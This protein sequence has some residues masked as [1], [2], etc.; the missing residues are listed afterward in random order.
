[1]TQHTWINPRAGEIVARVVSDGI[2]PTRRT[3]ME[4]IDKAREVITTHLDRNPATYYDIVSVGIEPWE[5]EKVVAVTVKHR[6]RAMV[7]EVW[8]V[9][10]TT[11]GAWE[12]TGVFGLVATTRGDAPL[13]YQTFEYDLKIKHKVA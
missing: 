10:F 7:V 5:D 2:Y 13:N 4:L 11:D 3:N 8:E 1:M 6:S 12:G 9:S